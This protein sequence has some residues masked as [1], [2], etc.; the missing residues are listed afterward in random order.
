MLAIRK[1]VYLLTTQPFPGGE[2]VARLKRMFKRFIWK[3]NVKIFLRQ[4]QQHIDI[5]EGGLKL[6]NLICF[7]KALKLS[8]IKR[9]ISGEEDW[10]TLFE[11][12][13]RLDKKQ[14]WELDSESLLIFGSKV[15]NNF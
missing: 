3:G 1:I 7:H 5:D 14:I 13:T 15:A 9:L 6:T 11:H 8:W 2:I 10:Q 12:E 4:L